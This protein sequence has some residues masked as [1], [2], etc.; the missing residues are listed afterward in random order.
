MAYGI[1]VGLRDRFEILVNDGTMDKCGPLSEVVLFRRIFQ[2]G[3][4]APRYL[5]RG[6][7]QD[8]ELCF[9]VSE[10]DIEDELRRIERSVRNGRS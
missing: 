9:D 5:V 1:E 10:E 2:I 4:L 7:Y 6:T 3:R 8:R